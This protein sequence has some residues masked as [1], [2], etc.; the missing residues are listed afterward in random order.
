MGT[1]ESK[2]RTGVIG[3]NRYTETLGKH[4]KD[5]VEFD[6]TVMIKDKF[7]YRICEIKI[8]HEYNKYIV[9]IQVYYEMDGKKI[10]AGSH[11]GDKSSKY[12]TFTLKDNEH[13][14]GATVRSGEWIDA[15]HLQTDTGRTFSVGGHGGGVTNFECPKGFQLVGFGG[16]TSQYLDSIYMFYDEL[17]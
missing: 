7:N 17:Y 11:V 16:S 15:I 12:E 10:S 3:T 8:Y 6:D 1:Q 4:K 2:P 5:S 14:I 13:I 9:G